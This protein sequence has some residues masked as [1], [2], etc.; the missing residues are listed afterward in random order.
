MFTLRLI[1]RNHLPMKFNSLIPHTKIAIGLFVFIDAIIVGTLGYM[2]IESYPFLDALYMTVITMASVGYGEVR[3]LSESGRIFTIFLIF[4]NIGIY[5]YFISLLSQ[6]VF[7]GELR[8]AYKKRKMKNRIQ[9]L[10]D[11]IIICGNGRN[12]REASNMLA[13]NLIPHVVIEKAYKPDEIEG[14]VPVSEYI[15]FADATNEDSLIEAGIKKARGLITA[16][17]DDSDNVYVVLTAKSLNP[18]IKVISRASTDSAV[19]RL[20]TA[21]ATNVIMPEKL[22]G[23]HMASLVLNPDINEFIDL[24][25]FQGNGDIKVSE[26]VSNKEIV[27]SELDLWKQYGVTILGVKTIQGEYLINPPHHYKLQCGMKLIVMGKI[28]VLDRVKTILA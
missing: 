15:L 20:K 4:I 19:K 7:D 22:G 3:P 14:S 27:L 23:A 10:E 11:H 12:G 28:D 26:I 9:K 1:Y 13:K 24:L 2:I 18:T 21:G 6:Y 17:A 8:K 16:L 5:S 25:S